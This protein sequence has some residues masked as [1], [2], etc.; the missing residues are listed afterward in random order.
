M[1]KSRMR[2]AGHVTHMGEKR[3]GYR[4]LVRR[5]FWTEEDLSDRRLEK[6]CI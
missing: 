4:T 1:I 5:I 3:N 6:N 2:W